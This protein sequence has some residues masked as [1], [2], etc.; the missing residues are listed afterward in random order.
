[1]S[2]IR[3]KLFFLMIAVAAVQVFAPRDTAAQGISP[4]TIDFFYTPDCPECGRIK[5]EIFPALKTRFEGFYTLNDFNLNKKE[6]NLVLI[7]YQNALGI[8]K[9]ESVCMVVD[10][11]YVFNGFGEIHKGLFDKI[12]ERVADRLRPDWREPAPIVDKNKPVEKGLADARVRTFTAMAI[13]AA[14]LIDGI[15]PCAIATIVFFMS[16]LAVFKVTGRALLFMGCAFC[17][18]AFVVYMAIG[19]GLLQIL[20][21]FVDV[22]LA[23]A[24]V[25]TVM[26]IILV[27]FAYLSFRDALQYW[28]TGK[29]DSV[30]LQLP[31]AVKMKMHDIMRRGLGAGSLV[32]GGFVIGAVVTALESVCTGQVYIPALVLVVASGAS[33]LHALWYLLLYNIMFIVPLI[34]VFAVTYCGLN[35]K[36]LTEWSKRNVVTSKVALGTFFIIMAILTVLM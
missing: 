5:N 1:M 27:L 14:G 21:T 22:P 2:A 13:I 33:R 29:V 17:A 11:K 15:N 32:A 18:G 6:N 31:H 10:Y 12:N 16:M 28:R 4:V 35:A 24:V 23:R 8:V 34:I 7:A 26:M 36:L 30:T 20:H 25:K 9:N 3:R 19:F